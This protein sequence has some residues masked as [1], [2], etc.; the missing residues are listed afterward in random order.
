VEGV[1]LENYA[2]LLSAIAVSGYKPEKSE[3]VRA[4][5]HESPSV[6]L[7]PPSFS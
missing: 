3:G 2:N 4:C 6:P 1:C 7:S 5:P